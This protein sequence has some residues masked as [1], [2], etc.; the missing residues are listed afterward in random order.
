MRVAELSVSE[1]EPFQHCLLPVSGRSFHGRVDGAPFN[2]GYPASIGSGIDSAMQ[3]F[4]F[5]SFVSWKKKLNTFLRHH[6]EV[7]H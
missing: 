5:I 6:M 7:T 3:S 2:R 4:L 1:L